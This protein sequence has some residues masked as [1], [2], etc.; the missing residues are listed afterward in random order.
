MAEN[1]LIPNRQYKDRLFRF[2]FQDKQ[3]L[4]SLYN[5]ING[6]S[7]ENPD[8]LEIRT[9][10]D[11]LYMGMKNDIS[12]LVDSRI[13]LYEEQS[14]WNPN[15]PLRGL[16]YFSRLYSGYVAE[17]DLDIYSSSKLKLPFP[18]FVVF[19]IG[20]DRKFKRR[21]LRLSDSFTPVDGIL[22]CIECTADIINIRAGYNDQLVNS[23]QKLYG[24]SFLICTIQDFLSQDHSLKEA[25]SR[26]IDIC[27]Q[28]GIL[29][30]FLKRYLA[31]V[32]NMLLNE[33]DEKQHMRR[34]KRDSI[35]Q[36]K[37]C[38]NLLVAKLIEA[39]RFDDLKRSAEDP[40][41]Q[42]QLLEEFHIGEDENLDDT[43]D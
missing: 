9:L 40:E 28:Q 1:Q 30:D 4:L 7:Y 20:Q 38:I 19:Y 17:K 27:I 37:Q 12:F 16:F 15:M 26:A 11:T 39:G 35:Q 41:F 10:D 43:D 3:D 32:T 23:C 13:N 34:L 42:E 36:G 8:D 33:Y 2:M 21:T 5:A 18:Q 14:S 29:A 25:I 6:S 31:E 24:Y 22:P